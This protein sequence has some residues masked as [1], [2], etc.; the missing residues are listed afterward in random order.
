MSPARIAG[1]NFLGIFHAGYDARS[2]GG[3]P[4]IR[5]SIIN[6]GSVM[7][8]LDLIVI[9]FGSFVAIVAMGIIALVAAHRH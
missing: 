3:V 8:A 5:G 4:F 2:N 7:A 9:G 1:T 6:R